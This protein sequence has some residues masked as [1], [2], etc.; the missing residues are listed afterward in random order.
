[1]DRALVSTPLLAAA[2]A[3][4][5]AEIA[6]AA[7]NPCRA[8]CKAAKQAC[9]AEAKTAFAEGKAAC[10]V[11]PAGAERKACK[12]AARAAFVAAKAGC[13]AEKLACAAACDTPVGPTCGDAEAEPVLG[14][15]AA[16][17]AVRANPS[18]HSNGTPQP[19]PDPPIPPLCYSASVAAVAQAWADNCQ[20]MHNAGRGNLGEN[21]YAE[22]GH[23]TGTA[24]SPLDAV[25]LWSAEAEW[26]DY[27]DPENC[28][29]PSPP[30]TCLHYTQVVWRDTT[31]IGCG[32]T[33]CTTN[34]PFG[35]DFPTWTYVVCDY[36]PPGNVTICAPPQGCALQKPY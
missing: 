33:R 10:A 12:Q 7:P 14:V 30:G 8:A 19:P 11:A 34:S 16:H 35:S 26:F 13:K 32:R 17:D 36:A 5:T 28:T 6:A 29:A 24:Q 2:L 22:A 20:Y 27:D 4:F 31:S 18:L 15:T 3:V 21:I 25:R 23:G 9:V 1:M